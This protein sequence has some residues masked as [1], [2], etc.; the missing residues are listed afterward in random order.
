MNSKLTHQ[1]LPESGTVIQTDFSVLN[2][3]RSYAQQRS[4]AL[5]E[6]LAAGTFS[7]ATPME[8]A[9]TTQCTRHIH[10]S[11]RTL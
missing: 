1:E 9:N 7:G 11:E 4:L 5:P 3:I 8:T 10:T 6:M 2:G